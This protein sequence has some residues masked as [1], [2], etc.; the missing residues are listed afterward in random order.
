MQWQRVEQKPEGHP[1]T[2]LPNGPSQIQ[3]PNPDSVADAKKHLLTGNW[4]ICPLRGSA[5]AN[6]YRYG[7]LQPLDWAWEPYGGVTRTEG[8]EGDCNPIGRTTISSNLTPQNC[9]GLNHQPKSSHGETHDSSC[10]CRKGLPYLA[11]VG[12]EDLDSV[13][14]HCPRV[15]GCYGSKAG[16]GGWVGQHCH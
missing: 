3:T 1:E 7:W 10:I 14:A 12:G 5:H 16:V 15:P 6:Q 2:T 13:E 11:S 9:Q 4:Y 8:V